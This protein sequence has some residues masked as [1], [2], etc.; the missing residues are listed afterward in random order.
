VSGFSDPIINGVNALLREKIMSP[1]Y[2]PGVSGWSINKDGTAEFSD[3]LARGD[4]S[5]SSLTIPAGAGP[6]TPRITIDA[7]GINV[8]DAGGV[9]LTISPFFVS[10]F[11]KQI[12][13]LPNGNTQLLMTDPQ[14]ILAVANGHGNVVQFGFAQGVFAGFDTAVPSDTMHP[15]TF[16]IGRGAIGG[17]YEEE[18]TLDQTQNF[19]NGVVTLITNMALINPLLFNDY[20]TM[21][22]PVT[23]VWTCPVTG[24]YTVTLELDWASWAAARVQILM[25]NSVSAAIVGIFDT[26]TTTGAATMTITKRFVAGDTYRFFAFQATGA[27]RGVSGNAYLSIAR[28]L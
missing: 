26:T 16:S 2:I 4:L 24:R 13:S 18:W 1:D 11:L 20:L 25:R 8:Y 17:N 28:H 15:G 22:N 3:V 10:L 5:G 6:G 27:A 9:V 7:T 19:A 21:L 12:D 14:A 23:G